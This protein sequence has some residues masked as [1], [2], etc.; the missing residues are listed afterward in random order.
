MRGHRRPHDG[1]ASAL[2]RAGF[3][4]LKL[5]FLYGMPGVGKLTAAREL[6]SLKGFR[7]FHNNP[8]VAGL[9]SAALRLPSIITGDPRH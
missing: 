1:R 6:A 3:S 4:I 8:A 5:I 7:L 9:M 2:D